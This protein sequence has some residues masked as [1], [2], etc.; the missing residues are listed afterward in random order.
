MTN[1]KKKK[2]SINKKL[3]LLTFILTFTFLSFNI[4][5]TNTVNLLSRQPNSIVVQ[6][7]GFSSGGFKSGSFS[8][9]SS[10]SGGFK[11]GSFSGSSKSG[12][13]SSGSFSSGK[14]SGGG[15]FGSSGSSSWSRSYTP[16]HSSWV[17]GGSRTAYY[18]GSFGGAVVKFIL[19]LI[20]AAVIYNIIKKSRR[21]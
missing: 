10:G 9:R 5:G 8:T 13:F 4:F 1:I 15:F 3:L 7:K 14:S 12:G 16:S 18:I 2:N 11:S 6:A 17:W 19:F 21:Y 20:V